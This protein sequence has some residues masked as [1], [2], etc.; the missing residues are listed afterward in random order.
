MD[1]SVLTTKMNST[2]PKWR[3]GLANLV[4]VRANTN[5]KIQL[6]EDIQGQSDIAMTKDMF[7]EGLHA[8]ADDGILTVMGEK[9][10]L[11]LNLL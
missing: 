3:E 1:I 5:S 7:E 10:L 9:C 11:A 2:S 8:L 6:F 4:Y